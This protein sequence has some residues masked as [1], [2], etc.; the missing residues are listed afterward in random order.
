MIL[1]IFLHR[2][3]LLI[4]KITEWNNINNSN[5]NNVKIV[6]HLTVTNKVLAEEKTS[7]HNE[8]HHLTTANKILAEEK[9]KLHIE[10]NHLKH[11]IN[12]LVSGNQKKIF[13]DIQKDIKNILNLISPKKVLGFNKIRI[14]SDNDGGYVM[15][16]SFSK[17][18]E[19]YSIGIG[20]N[21]EWDKYFANMNKTVFQYDHT[22]EDS[23]IKMPNLIFNKLGISNY[24][25]NNNFTTIED[26]IKK[27][28]HENNNNLILKMD[29]EGDEWNVF[30]DLS[31]IYLKK[32]EQIVI[33]FHQMNLL[34]DNY[35]R[36]KCKLVFNKLI[37]FHTP[38]HIHANNYCPVNIIYGI[39]LPQLLEVT[40]IRNDNYQFEIETDSFPQKLDMPCKK[41]EYDIS[42]GMFKF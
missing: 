33:E 42:L 7:L 21:V 3:N 36:N 12:V 11:E 17:E 9:T 28:G 8:N 5:I 16:D 39:P 27:N 35:F 4:V 24:I 32:F 29:I 14:G 38:I 34:E 18:S 23:P 22:V 19:C 1:N 2:F 15:L 6:N 37:K 25:I 40:F 41:G 30:E 13:P 26:E 31:E 20:Y 10:N